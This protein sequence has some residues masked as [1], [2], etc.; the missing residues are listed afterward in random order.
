VRLTDVQVAD[1]PLDE[2]LRC[3][4]IWIDIAHFEY[5]CANAD[6]QQAATGLRLPP[7]LP[8]EIHVRYLKCPQCAKLMNRMNYASRSGIIISVCRAHGIWL[9]RDEMRQII[10]SF[11]PAPGPAA[12]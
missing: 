5:L 9:D 3:G 10:E 12:S 11:V 4:G 6:A 8:I 1:T 2:C 7:P